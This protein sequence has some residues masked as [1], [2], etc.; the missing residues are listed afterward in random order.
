MKEDSQ[1][2]VGNKYKK[3]LLSVFLASS[4]EQFFSLFYGK[5]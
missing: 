4:Q 2:F 5:K 3:G 1:E